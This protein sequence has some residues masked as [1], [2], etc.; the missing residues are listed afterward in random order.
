MSHPFFKDI[1][2]EDLRNKRTPAPF[3]PYVSGPEDT[4][5]IDKLFTNEAVQETL[6]PRSQRL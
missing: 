6:D 4:R 1:N 3:K 5:N 2:W